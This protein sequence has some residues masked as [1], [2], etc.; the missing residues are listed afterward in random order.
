[1]QLKD[2]AGLAYS[3]ASRAALDA[4]LTALDEFHSFIDDPLTRLEAAIADS[5]RFVMAHVLKTY[6]CLLGTN[7][8]TQAIGVAAFEIAAGLDADDRERGHRK[9]IT[10]LL[11]NSLIDAARVLE[12]IALAWPADALALQVGQLLDLLIGDSRMLRDRI[13]RALPS[14]SRE[15]PGYHAVLGMAAFGL[16]EMGDYARAEAAGL[17][18]LSLNR[19][20][21]WAT[22][23]VAHVF[24]MQDRRAEGVC[25]MRATEGDWGKDSSFAV[26][27]WW[28]LALFHLG[29]DQ[30]EE[31]LR[32]YDGPIYG[33]AS[34]FE[35]DMVDASAL[36]WRLHLRGVDLGDRWDA[37]ADN[38]EGRM[39]ASNYGFSDAHA[40][41]A[42]VGAGRRE[43]TVILQHA[44]AHALNGED[45][46]VM[47][48]GEVGGPV[49]RAL[50]AFGEARYGDCIELLRPVRNRAARFGG[51]H[52]Q[53]DLIDLTLLE[54]ARRDGQEALFKGLY[55]ERAHAR[56]GPVTADPLSRAA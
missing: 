56:P 50:A 55:A 6:M 21:T 18:A 33:A 48:V 32:L 29:Q 16:E 37:L 8:A 17:E 1:M 54:A 42:F 19:R 45:D 46:N 31:V 22:H 49:V 24:E 27:N 53:R 44:Q 34:D 52:A 40:A 43:S 12:D 41:M 28:H 25:W 20:N 13:G 35:F 2:Q 38:W 30:V 39:H 9:A 26:H 15:M 23:A 3:G 36:L 5:P 51:S 14:W 7:A 10:L 11:Q 4:Y 47:F